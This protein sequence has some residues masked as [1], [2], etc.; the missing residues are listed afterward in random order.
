M[1]LGEDEDETAKFPTN[2]LI[3]PT[4]ISDNEKSNAR[5]SIYILAIIFLISSFIMIYIYMMFPKLNEYVK[6]SMTNQ[7][8]FVC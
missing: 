6:L 5:K 8:F 3:I 2:T 7:F 1:F 4:E